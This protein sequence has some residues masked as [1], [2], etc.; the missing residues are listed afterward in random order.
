MLWHNSFTIPTS[1]P[2]AWLYS[3]HMAARIVE[4][5]IHVDQGGPLSSLVR[6]SLDFRQS[7]VA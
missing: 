2:F 6:V 5:A 1:D 4:Y 7:G 3:I